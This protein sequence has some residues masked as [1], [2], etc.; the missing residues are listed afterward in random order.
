M[1]MASKKYIDHNIIVINDV[2]RPIDE[3]DYPEMLR[4]RIILGHDIRTIKNNLDEADCRPQKPDWYWKAIYA[5]D[6]KTTQTELLDLAI[7]REQ[8]LLAIEQED[9]TIECPVSSFFV[10][11]ARGEM[12]A[13][14]FSSLLEKAKAMFLDRSKLEEGREN[15]PNSEV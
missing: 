1:E 4:T 13:D 7:E 11:L 6:I 9:S 2:E 10:D 14:M 12:T 5:R 3:M 8:I 15:D